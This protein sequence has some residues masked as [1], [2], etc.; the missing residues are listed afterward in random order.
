MVQR[1]REAMH[2]RRVA[3]DWCRGVG[4]VALALMNLFA[5]WQHPATWASAFD[6][7]AANG[8]LLWMTIPL[9]VLGLVCLLIGARLARS[10]GAEDDEE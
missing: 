7:L 1:Q 6:A 3:R 4:V 8:F 10:V 5:P 9:L 2:R